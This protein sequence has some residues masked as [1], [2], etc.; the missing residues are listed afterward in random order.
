MHRTILKRRIRESVTVDT[1]RSTRVN[2][3]EEMW[4]RLFVDDFG[5]Y[6]SCARR[7]FLPLCPPSCISAV[8]FPRC[9]CATRC[10]ENSR[11][12]SAAGCSLHNAVVTYRV[13]ISLPGRGLTANTAGHRPIF[14]RDS[15]INGNVVI[16]GLQPA[17]IQNV[18]K[19]QAKTLYSLINFN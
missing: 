19:L 8:A 9:V 1:S 3:Q 10:D 14:S 4:P 6:F 16:S 2:L 17:A 15:S 11:M 12:H 18:L 13:C 7:V 5:I